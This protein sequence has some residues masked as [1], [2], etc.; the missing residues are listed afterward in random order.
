MERIVFLVEGTSQRIGCLLNPSSFTVQRNAG[1]RPLHSLGGA[2]ASAPF[3]D[4]PLLFTGGG[5]TEISLD[6][7]FDVS[8]PG[9]SVQSEDVRDLT[10]PLVELTENLQ[11]PRAGY[12]SLPRVRVLWGKALNVAAVVSAVSERFEHFTRVGVPRRSWLR[13]NLIRV[14]DDESALPAPSEDLLTGA[15]PSAPLPA[16]EPAPQSHAVIGGA[17][18]EDDTSLDRIDSLAERIF[19]D[20]RHWRLLAERADLD[21]PLR[22]PSGTLIQLAPGARP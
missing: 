9:S 18:G 10:R 12:A 1:L 20:V 11:P 2:A 22:I 6:L 7:L 4:D 13:M 14:H 15:T 17:R 3:R 19:G 8:V 5:R 16:V 21:D